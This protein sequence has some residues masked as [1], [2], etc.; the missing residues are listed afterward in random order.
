MAN[1]LCTLFNFRRL[2]T[3][4]SVYELGS[5]GLVFFMELKTDSWARLGTS[6]YS[7]LLVSLI[8][9]MPIILLAFMVLVANFSGSPKL[10]VVVLI[11]EEI[12]L[13]VFLS[14]KNSGSVP[15]NWYM[16]TSV[17]SKDEEVEKSTAS[18]IINWIEELLLTDTVVFSGIF[19]A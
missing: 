5:L 14:K 2:G 13:L 3:V 6:K 19:N 8:S 15:D 10:K 7:L 11:V 9:N 1:L 16:E 18:S 17:G 4:L 12:A